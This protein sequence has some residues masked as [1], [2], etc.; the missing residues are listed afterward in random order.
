MVVLMSDDGVMVLAHGQ[1][2]DRQ[3][4]TDLLNAAPPWR[5]YEIHD[6]R[7]ISLD[8]DRAILVYTGRTYRDEAE[9]EFTA[10]MS[11]VYMRLE[12][13]WRF[14]LYSRLPFPTRRSSVRSL[15]A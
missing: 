2:L 7:I 9:P 1:I 13:V 14:A 3:A 15:V 11:S 6:E 8:D 4:I 10:L 5:R 12:G